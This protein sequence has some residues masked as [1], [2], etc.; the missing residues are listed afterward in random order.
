MRNV[1]M[2]ICYKN[3]KDKRKIEKLICKLVIYVQ[4]STDKSSVS[5]DFLKGMDTVT[6]NVKNLDSIEYYLKILSSGCLN[7]PNF[8]SQAISIIGT[9]KEILEFIKYKIPDLESKNKIMI[10]KGNEYFSI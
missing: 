6:V 1:I 8:K 2:A 3:E 7:N 4:K 9:R 10:L 5:I